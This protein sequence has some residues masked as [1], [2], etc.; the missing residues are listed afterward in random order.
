MSRSA[1]DFFVFLQAVIRKNEGDFN[2][3]N[4]FDN[5]G[6]YKKCRILPQV[7]ISQNELLKTLVHQYASHQRAL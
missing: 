2:G 4:T 1:N 3:E 7:S 5:K 6:C